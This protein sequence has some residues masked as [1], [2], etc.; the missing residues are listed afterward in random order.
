MKPNLST[1]KF[2][3]CSVSGA[4]LTNLKLR[5]QLLFREKEGATIV[6]ERKIADN[7]KLK[8]AGAWAMIT[9]DVHSDLSAV[10]FLAVVCG[11]L[12]K[13][14]ISVNAVSAYY[15][16]H[17]FVPFGKRKKALKLLKELSSKK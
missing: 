16:D 12:A 9:L 10:G 17:L 2:V 14:E 5:P 6:V 8:Y 1:K 15:H 11:K 3:F 4:V 7:A 13:N